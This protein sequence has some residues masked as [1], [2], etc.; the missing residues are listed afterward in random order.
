MK[1]Y[2][3]IVSTLALLLA[4]GG[5]SYAVTALPRNSVGTAQIKPHA[6]TA[7]KLALGVLT[8]GS[9]GP[10]GTPARGVRKGT[11]ACRALQG[12]GATLAQ[13]AR[14]ARVVRL[15]SMASTALRAFLAPLEQTAWMALPESPVTRW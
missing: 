8:P 7:G 9:Q 4:L 12:R 10:V 3:K 15:A 6:V 14:A 13:Q 2:S 5:T 1:H 11:A